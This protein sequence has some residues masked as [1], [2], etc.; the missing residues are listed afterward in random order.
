MAAPVTGTVQFDGLVL[1]NC[2][3]TIS[4]P[5]VLDV[6]PGGSEMNTATGLGVPARAAIVAT[7]GNFSVSVTPTS[8]F[9]LAP[10]GGNAGTTFETKYSSS[11]ATVAVNV[12]S[13][14]PTQLGIGLSNLTINL[15]AT[16]SSPFPAGVYN[17]Q[18]VVTCE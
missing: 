5:G 10:A 4:A 14:T 13:G 2:A 12:L 8:T 6:A 11:G 17:A 18:A 9:A 3:I 15:K 1:P 7:G 16:H